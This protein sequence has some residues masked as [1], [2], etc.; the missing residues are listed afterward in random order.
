MADYLAEISAT[1]SSIADLTA[2]RTDLVI[3][4]RAAG[5]DITAIAD[6][7][8]ASRQTIYRWIEAAG[9]DGHKPESRAVLRDC[10]RMCASYAD[11]KLDAPD[12]A[13]QLMALADG[14]PQMQFRAMQMARSWI[15]PAALRGDLTDEDK[16]LLVNA[17]MAEDRLRRYIAAQNRA[18]DT[19]DS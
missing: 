4:A 15:L 12:Y 1:T 10:I 19:A 8:R 9:G 13:R 6:A 3:A 2:H 16:A 11:E 17:T 14:D 7:A 5:I 18:D